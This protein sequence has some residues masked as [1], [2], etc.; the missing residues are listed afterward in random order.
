MWAIAAAIAGYEVT[1]FF[2]FSTVTTSLLMFIL[3]ASAM[4]IDGQTKGKE[5]NLSFLKS[6]IPQ[7]ATLGTVGA[8]GLY[9]II[10]VVRLFLADVLEN[11]AKSSNWENPQTLLVFTNAI[12]TSPVAN[13]FYLS[14]AA[15]AFASYSTSSQKEENIWSK[16]QSAKLAKEAQE[17]SGQN[18]IIAR[19]IASAYILL[20]H[21]DE[22]FY[23]EAQKIGQI[24]VALA[25]TDPQSYLTLAKIQIT[26]E[27]NEKAKDSLQKA[28]ELKPNY[29][30]AQ[31]LLEQ[32]TIDN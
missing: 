13:P 32:L 10:F 5:I 15:F 1:I 6:K 20:A 27:E 26:T 25:P 22:S 24:I 31:E 16:E 4:K 30:E 12:S 21:I 29:K 23:N 19:R 9:I 18:I 2:G 14:D 17:I 11:R 7:I 28:L 3:I 8:F